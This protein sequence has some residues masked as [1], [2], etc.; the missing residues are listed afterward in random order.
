MFTSRFAAQKIAFGS[1]IPGSFNNNRLHA[2]PGI[3]A[4]TLQINERSGRGAVLFIAVAFALLIALRPVSL[5][6]QSAASVSGTITDTSGAVVP[7]V[8]IVLQNS[9]T[10]VKQITL[11]NSKGVYSFISVTPG[12]YSMEV[13]KN[14]F[15]STNETKVV[16]SVNQSALFN[17][18]IAPS[19]VQQ[20]VTVSS[21]PGSMQS[22]SATLGTVITRKSV[23][24]LPLNGRNFTELLE[25]TPGVSRLGDSQAVLQNGGQTSHFIGTFTLPSVNG[26]RNRSDM[27]MM[28]GSND[29]NSYNG[30]YNYQPIIDDIQEF[31]VQSHSDLAEYGQETGAIVN[32][33]TKSGTNQLHGSLWEFLRNSIFDARD[34][35]QPKVN[36]LRQNQFGVTAGGPVIIPHVYTGL[37]RTFFFFAY[38]G[39]RQSQANQ[40]VLTTPTPAQLRGDFS[41]LLAKGVQLYNPFSTRP[42]PAHP[43]EYLRDPFPNDQIP[44]NLI[45]NAALIYAKAFF[46]AP[47]N[48]VVV[49]GNAYDNTPILTD[50]D[51]YTG[52]LDQAFGTHDF[53]FVRAS[54]FN[55]PYS[56]S[57]DVPAHAKIEGEA[58]RRFHLIL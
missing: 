31:K 48:G 46:P 55:E 18:T 15:A 53:F 25:L 36:P 13:I 45:S 56:S 24:D 7:G 47:A 38:E 39:F 27:Y 54:S 52:R 35:F 41:N 58:R 44:G 12:S 4:W 14:G 22:T 9:D 30:A 11:T 37:N 29:I 2:E 20:T 50:S 51:S 34:Y 8:Q 21:N 1:K 26:Q 49:G 17:F 40:A 5:Q 57:G 43:G 6:A 23:N 32:V 28:D 16:L 10:N 3:T 33:V 19:S 42:D